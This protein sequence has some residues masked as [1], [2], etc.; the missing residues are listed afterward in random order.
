MWFPHKPPK[1]KSIGNK[2]LELRLSVSHEWVD[3]IGSLFSSCTLPALGVHI[4]VH[5]EKTKCK[6]S[7]LLPPL[8]S[9]TFSAASS[10]S[11]AKLHSIFKRKQHI[12][13]EGK[14]IDKHNWLHLL[15]MEG[16][17]KSASGALF[18]DVWLLPPPSSFRVRLGLTS[19]PE[20]ADLTISWAAWRPGPSSSQVGVGPVL[21]LAMWTLPVHQRQVTSTGFSFS[22]F[23]SH[24]QNLALSF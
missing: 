22:F 2:I 16:N 13:K 21:N 8:T 24:T 7:Y 23:H 14:S 12:R 11:F 6:M 10:G 9:C 19:V 18:A 1:A 15:I 4:G 3:C 5:L 17:K 20:E